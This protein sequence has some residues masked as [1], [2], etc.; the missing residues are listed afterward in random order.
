VTWLA[1]IAYPIVRPVLVE[2]PRFLGVGPI[3][4]RWY[5]VSY[6]LAFVLAFLVLRYLAKRKRWPV[7]PDRVADVLFWGILGVF[8]GGRIGYVLF[9]ALPQGRFDWG[10]IYQVWKGGM[11]FHGG[12]LGVVIAYWIYTAR[13]GL[14]RGDFFDGLSLATAPGI[15]LV[16]AANFV[17]AEL[18]GRPW[19]G[20]WA[21]SFP[22]YPA[23]RPEDWDGV[24]FTEPRHPSQIYE[25]LGEGLLLFLVLHWLMMRRGWGGGKISGMFLVLYGLVR[26]LVEFVRE[27]DAGIGFDLLGTITRGQVLC[28]AMMVLGLVTL[29]RSGGKPRIAGGAAA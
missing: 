14:P 19:D 2:I 7:A 3:K 28:V 20:P 16:R 18:Y 22:V 15:F 21:M 9:Y 25:A 4:V 24:T 5:G 1:E 12:L 13:T 27:P 11:S 8:L 6:I 10:E 23:E 29:A 17:N 26:F